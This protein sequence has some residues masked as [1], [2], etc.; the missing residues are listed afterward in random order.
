MSLTITERRNEIVNRLNRHP[1]WEAKYKEV[2]D[3]GKSLELMPEPFKVPAN[4]VKG[5]Q[6]QVW[7]HV[8]TQA[9]GT[10]KIYGDSDAVIVKGLVALLIYVYSTATAREILEMPADF[11]K[12]IGFEGNLSQTRANGLAAMIKQI[13]LYATVL[14]M[15]QKK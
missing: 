14:S 11:I 2:I 12:E 5:C 8:E 9:D 3:L 7:M 6:S 13:K 15:T 4:L 10:V 1:D